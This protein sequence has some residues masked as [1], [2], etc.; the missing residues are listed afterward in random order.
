MRQ[1]LVSAPL[2]LLL[3]ASPARAADSFEGCSG[4]IDSVPATISTQ[5]VW[6]LRGDLATALDSGAAITVAVNNVTIDCNQFKLGGLA[7]GPSSQA[8]GVFSERA[9]TTVRNCNIRGFFVGALIESAGG[10]LVEAN[11]FDGN[12]SSSIRMFGAGSIVRNNRV[13]DTGGSTTSTGSA[14]GIYSL[15]TVDITGNTISNVSS[16]GDN[17]TTF[18]ILTSMNGGGSIR[19]NRIH[20]VLANGAGGEAHGIYNASSGRIVLRG[21]DVKGVAAPG[22]TGLRCASAQGTAFENVVAGFP[23]GIQTC[24][25]SGNYINNN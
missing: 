12:L 4:F 1:I 14:I 23:T 6:C 25:Q 13:F 18:G 10:N 16:L 24:S 7:A 8:V 3:A 5:G 17:N 9:N 20:A 2:L 21:N 11:R 19:D 22:G 15:G